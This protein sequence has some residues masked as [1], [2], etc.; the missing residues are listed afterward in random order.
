[1]FVWVIGI[2]LYVL[3]ALW[4]NRKYLYDHKPEHRVRHEEVVEEFGTLFLQ[5]EPAY[6]YWEVTVIFKK[7]MLTG[8]M[9]IIEPGT[10]VQLVI[11]L[12]VVLFNMLLILKIGPFV[13]DA[14]DWLSFTTSLQMLLTLIGGLLIKTDN[15]VNPSYDP[16]VMGTLLVVINSVGLVALAFSI[17]AMHPNVRACLNN[18]G[19]GITI[20]SNGSGEAENQPTENRPTKVTP[21]GRTKDRER[22]EGEFRSWGD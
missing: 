22:T 18:G 12:L 10:S 9:T 2:P 11:A 14:D 5:Y 7:M 1:M 6:W 16:G 15:P 4:F 13:D 17:V 21:W 3:L 20:N 8:A 19:R